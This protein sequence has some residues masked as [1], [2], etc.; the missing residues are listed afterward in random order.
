MTSF[1]SQLS[2]LIRPSF[3]TLALT[4]VLT[5]SVGGSPALTAPVRLSSNVTN[6][7]TLA[8]E[9]P[10]IDWNGTGS[11]CEKCSAQ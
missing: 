2:S 3:A 4:V 8:M 10:R 1:K 11:D 7:G 9:N 6:H 5:G